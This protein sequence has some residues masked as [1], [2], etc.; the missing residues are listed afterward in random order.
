M[1][2]DGWDTVIIFVMPRILLLFQK[3]SVVPHVTLCWSK[4]ELC[5]DIEP[6]DVTGRNAFDQKTFVKSFGLILTSEK[7]YK[8]YSWFHSAKVSSRQYL[9]FSQLVFSFFV[10]E[11][12]YFCNFCNNVSAEILRKCY[13]EAF[14]PTG[15]LQL[16]LRQESQCIATHRYS[17]LLS[18]CRKLCQFLLTAS[19]QNPAQTLRRKYGAWKWLRR[20]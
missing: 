19:S 9:G 12:Q 14:N 2:L 20:L 17:R 10:D 7:I 6:D 11:N 13:K 15:R 1:L 16:A 4:H 18:M 8:G 3:I 5:S